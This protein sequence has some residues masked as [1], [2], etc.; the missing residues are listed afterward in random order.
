MSAKTTARIPLPS[1]SELYLS[2]LRAQQ[3]SPATLALY[4]TAHRGFTRYLS[5]RLGRTPTLADLTIEHARAYAIHLGERGLHPNSLVHYLGALQ[6]WGA[7]L[8]EEEELL[9]SNPLA[10][11]R[12]PRRVPTEI[13]P[14]TPD[15][16]ARMVAM[17][18][19]SHEALRNRAALLLLADTGLRVS[20]LCSLK[21]ADLEYATAEAHGR[22]RVVGKGRKERTAHFG[23]KASRAVQTYVMLGRPREAG[24][25]EVFLS[26]DGRPWTRQAVGKVVR[27]LGERA[28]IA[29]KRV[30]PH[31]LRHSFGTEYAKAHPGQAF[32]LQALL[33]H[34]S[35]GTTREY[36]HLGSLD[37]QRNYASLV[38]GWKQV[39][40]EPS[41]R[42]RR[43]E[44]AS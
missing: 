2:A 35:M 13:Q 44:R 39:R 28:G 41:R 42:A 16:I 33:G 34:A 12:V 5:E 27:L 17:A 6:R 7:F 9:P 25:G 29:G 26:H 36:L 21:L 8:A 18:A 23:G 15:E 32:Q 40:A 22:V 14:L 11:L 38:D 30:S 10:R 20:E 1:L 31:S 19:G 4:D 24:V 3:S 43:P 37:V